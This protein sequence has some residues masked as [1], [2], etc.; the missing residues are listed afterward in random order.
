MS[1]RKYIL[2]ILENTGLMGA[3]LVETP[4]LGS[5]DT[6]PEATY[7]CRILRTHRHAWDTRETRIGHATWRVDF[8]L[9][10]LSSDPRVPSV[11]IFLLLI[12]FFF[13]DSFSSPSP[14]SSIMIVAACCSMDG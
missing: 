11:S 13:A 4:K 10:I 9:L 3:K 8:L 2:D 14:P 7:P 5:T 6:P 12:L 1:Q